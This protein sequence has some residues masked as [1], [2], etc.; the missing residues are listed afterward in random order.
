MTTQKFVVTERKTESINLRMAP[1][2][3]ELLRRAAAQERRTLS[4]FI[5]FLV[6]DYCDKN[7]ISVS[8]SMPK[9][10]EK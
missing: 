6:F 8:V 4:N 7:G 10:K 5:E 3:K 9:T 1:T 2:T